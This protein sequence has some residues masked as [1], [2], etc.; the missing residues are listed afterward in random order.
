MHGNKQF[1]IIYQVIAFFYGLVKTP[2]DEVVFS[3]QWQR[4]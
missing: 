3:S 2:K 1:E 4:T